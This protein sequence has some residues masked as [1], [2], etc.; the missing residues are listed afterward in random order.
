[1]ESSAAFTKGGGGEHTIPHGQRERPPQAGRGWN[2]P[3]KKKIETVWTRDGQDAG[4]EA[5]FPRTYKSSRILRAAH[6]AC[7][8]Q[9]WIQHIVNNW[10]ASKHWRYMHTW[11]ECIHS[12]HGRSILWRRTINLLITLSQLNIK[13]VFLVISAVKCDLITVQVGEKN[14]HIQKCSRL[15]KCI[16]LKPLVS[17]SAVYCQ[18]LLIPTGGEYF[19]QRGLQW[20]GETSTNNIVFMNMDFTSKVCRDVDGSGI[21][22]AVNRAVA[23]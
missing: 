12:S 6:A 3:S 2:D 21:S 13:L 22:S 17:S 11:S 18:A 23:L 7:V 9:E 5:T 20:G 8:S 16:C 19:N 14:T 15:W 4:R 1:M 10:C